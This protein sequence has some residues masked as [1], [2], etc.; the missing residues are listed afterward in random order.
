[1]L[2]YLPL[3]IDVLALRVMFPTTP[4]VLQINMMVLLHQ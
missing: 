2:E 4:E 1:M 3:P